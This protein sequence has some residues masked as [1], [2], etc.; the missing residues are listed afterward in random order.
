MMEFYINHTLQEIERTPSVEWEEDD[1]IERTTI[2]LDIEEEFFAMVKLIDDYAYMIGEEDRQ[3][4]M[5]DIDLERKM[6]EQYD[7]M[8]KQ[9]DDDSNS[10]GSWKGWDEPGG[11]FDC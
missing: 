10:V 9:T 11:A 4:F 5:H 1:H 8:I 3:L 2:R 6:S 7:A